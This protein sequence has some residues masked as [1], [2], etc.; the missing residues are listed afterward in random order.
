[1]FDSIKPSS[2]YLKSYELVMI[3]N[4]D[5]TLD[6]QKRFEKKQSDY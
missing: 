2:D 3:L 5:S 4:P 6:Q 1:M